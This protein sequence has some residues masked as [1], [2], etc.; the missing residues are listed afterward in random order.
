MRMYRGLWQ[1]PLI[2]MLGLGLSAAI[3]DTQ[4]AEGW[5]EP[6]LA[7]L[8]DRED[9]GDQPIAIAAPATDAA[10]PLAG[11]VSRSRG[12]QD[13]NAALPDAP[14]SAAVAVSPGGPKHAASV[15]LPTL[16]C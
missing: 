9:V 2:L 6:A 15:I 3:L 16:R 4:A 7:S 11:G 1:V 14:A 10:R 5:D 8:C 13:A 12:L